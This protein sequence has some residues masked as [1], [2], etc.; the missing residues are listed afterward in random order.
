MNT[1]RKG[2]LLLL[3]MAVGAYAC[4]EWQGR[5]PSSPSVSTA[6]GDS[7]GAAAVKSATPLSAVVQ[8][9][10][11]DTG[12]PFPPAEQHDQSAHAKDNLTPRNV[13]IDVDGSVT[14]EMPANV[15]QLAIYLPGKEPDDVDV[16]ST[17]AAP[18]PCPAF[19]PLIND[20]VMRLTQQTR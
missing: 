3:P 13:V 5:S 14:F 17:I 6:L 10:R 16:G 4:S 18:A 12:S 11:P 8:F 1:V 2:W 20:P 9:G 19:I 15:H 7:S